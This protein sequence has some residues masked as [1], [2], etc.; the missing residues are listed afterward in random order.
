MK[1]S[2][3]VCGGIVRRPSS[4]VSSVNRR[5]KGSFNNC[6]R[7]L[8]RAV[9][10]IDDSIV[11]S[12]F[13]SP[14]PR[15]WLPVGHENPQ[16]D[17]FCNSSPSVMLFRA[18]WR[19]EGEIRRVTAQTAV[20]Q[21]RASGRLIG[22]WTWRISSAHSG[23]FRMVK[24]NPECHCIELH[25][26]QG[27]GVTMSPCRTFFPR[28]VRNPVALSFESRAVPQV[29][30]PFLDPVLFKIQIPV[31]VKLVTPGFSLWKRHRFSTPR[32]E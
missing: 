27:S 19:V 20:D 11:C 7:A 4:F 18:L 31:V 23:S 14:S 3:I 16:I 30:L 22:A 24:G 1:L 28:D 32:Q 8:C 5:G 25:S 10:Q 2:F 12:H 9:I 21:L 17:R 29:C 26:Q 15:R 6:A 13:C